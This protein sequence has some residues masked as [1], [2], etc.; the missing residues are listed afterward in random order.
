MT[1]LSSHGK[2]VLIMFDLTQRQIQILKQIVREY[3]DTAEP[4]GSETLEKKYDLG[5]SPATIR[6][7]MAEM[8]KLGYLAKPHS[9]SG[10]IPTSRAL[11]LY[12]GELM[13]EKELTVAEEV[14]T[15]E[16]VWDARR[17]EAKFL[18][19]ATRCLAQK[20]KALAVATTDTGDVFFAGY[21]NILKMPEFYDI[22]V[23]ENFL[24]ILD[25]IAYFNS[26]MQKV[27]S[28]F[29]VLLGDELGDELLRP[30]GIILSK[31]HTKQSHTGCI[32]VLG[33]AR[34][35]YEAIVPYVKRYGVI[36]DEIAEW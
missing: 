22:S 31:F 14:E 30:Y 36:I 21:A 24:S 17:D 26:L 9:S 20:T 27:D 33:P 12:V 6:N 29:A 10:R 23:T 13:R 35:R 2:I 3:I 34:L 28:D 18:R 19:E 5:V 16:K 1:I 4:V 25:N 8:V 11:K 32:G 15:K 7:E